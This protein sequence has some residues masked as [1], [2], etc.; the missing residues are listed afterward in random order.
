MHIIK[1]LVLVGFV[2]CLL[3]FIFTITYLGVNDAL[4]KKVN[5]TLKKQEKTNILRFSNKSE[6]YFNTTNSNI[7]E[8]TSKKKELKIIKTYDL[9]INEESKFDLEHFKNIFLVDTDR[10]KVFLRLEDFLFKTIELN[11]LKLMNYVYDDNSV[12]LLT[13]TK[14]HFEDDDNLLSDAISF[15]MKAV[16]CSDEPLFMHK[17]RLFCFLRNLF[18]SNIEE[19]DSIDDSEDNLFP[20]SR[21]IYYADLYQEE[22]KIKYL[23]YFSA[24][25]ELT[26]YDYFI[27]RKNQNTDYDKMRVK[28]RSQ[29]ND[30]M[31]NK[32][33]NDTNFLN[34]LNEVEIKDVQNMICALNPLKSY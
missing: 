9:C 7:V 30:D 23:L 6:S 16:K 27:V 22:I 24:T 15:I 21:L 11:N 12:S 13:V 29:N 33:Q 26:K 28:A 14:V 20:A 5:K 25:N 31:S 18:E 4:N 10:N 32:I 8:T 34:N 2:I 1:I 17:I 3:G 19:N